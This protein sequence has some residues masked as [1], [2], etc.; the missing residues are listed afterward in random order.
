VR[1]LVGLAAGGVLGLSVCVS[2]AQAGLGED[3]RQANDLDLAIRAC[4]ELIRGNPR[5]AAAFANR[6]VA[7]FEKGDYDQAMP[8]YNTAIRL[9][10]QDAAAH[11][12]RGAA[13]AQNGDWARAIAD[14]DKAIKLAPRSSVHYRM[15]GDTY[16]KKGEGDRAFADYDQAIRLAPQSEAS[17]Y[18]GRG[19]AYAF[20]GAWDQAIADHNKAIEIY[21]STPLYVFRRGQTYEALGNRTK[22]ISDYERAL[23]IPAR[24][25]Q[26]KDAQATAKGRLAALRAVQP[27]PAP[28]APVAAPVVIPAPSP[29]AVAPLA[30]APAPAALGRRVALVI[31]NA[32][33]KVGPLQNPVN[34]AKAMADV[35]R[36]TLKFDKVMLRLNLEFDAFRTA[37]REFSRESAGADLGLVYFAGHGTEVAGKNYLVP[38]D[39]TLAKVGDLSIEAMALDSVLDQLAGVTKLRLVILDACRNNPFPVAR[40]GSRGLGRIEPGSNTLVVYAAKDGT[41]ADDGA[42]RRHSPFTEA[43]LKHIA[44][45]ALEIQFLFREVRDDV[46]AATQG[47]QEP[48]VYGTLGRS[49]MYLRL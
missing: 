28:P 19:A 4:S 5:D 12:N 2:A 20:K 46:T 26:E 10:P 3:C 42:G 17:G 9:N 27:A 35:L 24:I 48:Y 21:S 34:D 8:D 31:G 33:Y 14:H 49:R 29:V 22:A 37:L 18:S 32:S 41:T 15:R 6:G 13:H 30:A 25:Q 36:D 39:A 11:T 23:A 47:G 1:Y 44:T 45:P 38:I 16:L 40:R 43:L 7:R